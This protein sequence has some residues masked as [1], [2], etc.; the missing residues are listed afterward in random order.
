MPNER[1]RRLIRVSSFV[2]LSSFVLR[3]SSF[4]RLPILTLLR[5][6][7][8]YWHGRHNRHNLRRKLGLFG[9]SGALRTIEIPIKNV[10]IRFDGD[11]KEKGLSP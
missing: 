5:L 11:L 10:T 6:A 3:H 8:H 4:R 1:D 7:R 2:L 9:T